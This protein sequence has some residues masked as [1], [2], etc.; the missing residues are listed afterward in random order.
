MPPLPLP[1]PPP[2]VAL[3]AEAADPAAGPAGPAAQPPPAESGVD[4]APPAAP[5][6]DAGRPPG[7]AAV[8]RP[9]PPPAPP[10]ASAAPAKSALPTARELRRDP[11][12]APLI[13]PPPGGA[14]RELLVS[15]NLNGRAVS[16]GTLFAERQGDG[17]TLAIQLAA[18]ELWRVGTDASRVITFQGEPYYPLAAIEGAKWVLDREGLALKLDIPAARFAATRLADEREAV[19]PP[20]A[21]TGGFLDYDLLLTGG[22]DLDRRLD[23]LVEAG[24]FSALGTLTSSLRLGD[25]ARGPEATRLDTTLTRDLPGRRASL[26]FGDSVAAGGA[27]AAPVRFGGL[28]YAT[29]FGTDPGFVTFPL[30]AIGG[31]AEQDAVVDVLIDNLARVSGEVPTGP[32]A[33]DNLPVVT[34]AGE[35]QLRV[36]DLLGRERLV[37]QPYYVSSRLL[38]PGLHDFSYELGFEREDFAAKSFAYGEPLASTTHRY[39]LTDRLTAEAHAEAEPDLQGV[40]AGGSYLLGG[41]RGVVSAGL[42]GSLAE[43]APGGLAELGYEYD[44]RA[45]NVSLRSRLAT[46][47]FEQAGGTEGVRRTD[48]ASLGVDLG[49]GIGRA[50]LLLLNRESYD[51]EDVTTVAATY[52]RPFGPGSFTVRAAQF[53]RPGT[54]TAV[55][56]GFS[57][58]LGPT[59]HLSTEVD[60]EGGSRRGRAQ[61]RQTRGASDLGLDY[62]LGLEA[63]D[64]GAGAGADARASYQSAVGTAEL[65]V[66]RMDGDDRLRAGVSGSLALVDGRVA[67]SRRIGRAFGLVALPG[68][69]DVRVYLDNREAGRTDGAGYL[70]LPGLRPYE[71]NRVRIE[72]QDL[73]LEAVL[74]GDEAVAVPFDRG[75]VTVAFAIRRGRSATVTLRDAEGRPLPAGLG[76]ASVDGGTVVRVA[77][78]GFAQVEG[79]AAAPREVAGES[80]GRRFAC[81]LPGAPEGGQ[82]PLPDLGEVSC[83]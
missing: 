81:A 39:G 83:R 51:D 8:R 14:W 49:G 78:G 13:D 73:P 1:D 62:R 57:L 5:T 53:F 45:F 79:V 74:V 15:V 28:Q 11:V 56:A 21:G 25:L 77:R 66:E 10:S 69:P 82:D 9:P 68:F 54:E 16:Q 7:R 26:R 46:S 37:T 17:G 76:L 75:G 42:G 72:P 44:G 65:E 33:V 24:A 67:A 35:V 2:P 80:G 41:R 4:G 60:L 34:G 18:L 43:G 47:D 29:N 19:P 32:F 6:A 71:A 58:P 22:D 55:T 63:G 23:G 70:L 27:F 20:A 12:E 31:L 61:F 64:D 36:T 50:G 59:R 52:S 40:V 38:K 48:Q 30:P 3:A